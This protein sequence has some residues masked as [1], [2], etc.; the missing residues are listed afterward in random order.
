MLSKE[1]QTLPEAKEI[2]VKLELR[3]AKEC[4]KHLPSSLERARSK[5]EEAIEHVDFWNFSR[6]CEYLEF[7][8]A[9]FHLTGLMTPAWHKYCN[10]LRNKGGPERLYLQG[11]SEEVRDK[12]TGACCRENCPISVHHN[13]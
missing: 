11:L 6:N 4:L 8:R 7:E 9:D 1:K 2:T 3:D 10:H 12:I 13:E 5:I